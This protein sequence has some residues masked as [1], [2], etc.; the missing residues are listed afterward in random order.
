MNNAAFVNCSTVDLPMASYLALTQCILFFKSHFLFNGYHKI[1]KSSSSV[2]SW[3]E[4]VRFK[5]SSSGIDASTYHKSQ[6]FRHCH[7][8]IMHQWLKT[9]FGFVD[10]KVVNVWKEIW[11]EVT[12]GTESAVR[13]YI[14]E[15]ISITDTALQSSSWHRKVRYQLAASGIW[16]GNVNEYP[17]MHCFG[18][19]RHGQSM[20]SYIIL[21]FWKFQWKIAL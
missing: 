2:S 6:L 18:N 3:K 17:T 13:L 12:I 11:N 20:I 15:F 14:Q 21:T 1:I 19:P 5:H 8:P 4:N 10:K 16:I 7:T 9:L